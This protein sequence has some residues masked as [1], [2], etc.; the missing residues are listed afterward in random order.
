MNTDFAGSTNTINICLILLT[1]YSF[2]PVSGVGRDPLH[3]PRTYNAV[4][5]ALLCT[6]L[7]WRNGYF[8]TWH[9]VKWSQWIWPECFVP[10]QIIYFKWEEKQLLPLHVG[11]RMKIIYMYL[12]LEIYMYLTLEMLFFGLKDV[13]C[14]RKTE[15]FC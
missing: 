7:M 1:I 11:E 2:I 6:I 14:R 8:R 9:V 13:L 12:T 15:C 5:T 3:C 10:P 4:K